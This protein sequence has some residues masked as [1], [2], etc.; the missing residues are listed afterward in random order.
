VSSR[1]A[2]EFSEKAFPSRR[3][4]LLQHFWET[5]L[6]LFLEALLAIGLHA[7]TQHVRFPD[8]LLDWTD[9]TLK[10]SCIATLQLFAI[11]S[12]MLQVLGSM[13]EILGAIARLPKKTQRAFKAGG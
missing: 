9:R 1:H 10:W 2:S 3:Q 5:V 11:E 13:R 8:G 7:A 4:L 12:L 6:L